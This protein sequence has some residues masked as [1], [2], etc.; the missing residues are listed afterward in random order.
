MSLCVPFSS[1]CD[2]LGHLGPLGTMLSHLGTFNL[3]SLECCSLE[4]TCSWM[5]V[6]I[7]DYG[8]FI[9]DYG[10][11]IMHV[12][13]VWIMH[14]TWI[15]N[16]WSWIYAYKWWIMDM[17]YGIWNIDYGLWLDALWIMD[18]SIIVTAYWSGCWYYQSISVPTPSMSFVSTWH[19]LFESM[20][21]VY[22]WY[23]CIGFI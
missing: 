9:V 5:D 12:H 7:V 13:I 1:T 19:V 20:I 3:S 18:Q 10:L 16:F 4:F 22:N 14:C 11:L 17:Y 8:L 15:M 21:Y 6:W 23:M 2:Q